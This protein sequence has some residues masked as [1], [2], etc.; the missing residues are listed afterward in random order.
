MPF[1]LNACG[2]SSD[3]AAGAAGA[4]TS[5]VYT[6]AGR[7]AARGSR[8]EGAVSGE[9][10]P[11]ETVVSVSYPPPLPDSHSPATQLVTRPWPWSSSQ[12]AL[13]ESYLIRCIVQRDTLGRNRP[14]LLRSREDNSWLRKSK[15]SWCRSRL[16]STRTIILPLISRH[17][18][19]D[20]SDKPFFKLGNHFN[21]S[22]QHKWAAAHGRK[23]S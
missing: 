6:G 13:S 2:G 4:V 20:R 12:H 5:T 11:P 3:L 8:R 7:I 14:T 1:C 22:S 18:L 21:L 16:M 9:R 17:T 15:C 19:K 10:E 23:F